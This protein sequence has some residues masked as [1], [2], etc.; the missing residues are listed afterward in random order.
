MIILFVNVDSND[1]IVKLRIGRLDEIVVRV[2]LVPHGVESLED[3]LEESVQVLGTRAG[4]EDVGVAEANGGG[5]GK[6]ESCGSEKVKLNQF[7]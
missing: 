2:F 5:N 7:K 1:G 4:H 6:A 3:E